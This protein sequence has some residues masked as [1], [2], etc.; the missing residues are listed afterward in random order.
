MCVQVPMYYPS[1]FEKQWKIHDN[2]PRNLQQVHRSQDII[3]YFNKEG[4][5]VSWYQDPISGHIYFDVCNECEEC[6]LERIFDLELLDLSSMSK[7]NGY[8]IPSIWIPKSYKK[9]TLP[10]KKDLHPYYQKCLDIS[11]KEAK[12]LNVEW[13][14]KSFCKSEPLISSHP[15]QVQECFMFREEDFPK[16][17]TFNK[18]GSRHTQKIQN[19]ASTVLPSGETVRPNPS[20]D[21][22]NWQTEK[23]LQHLS[24]IGRH[25]F[26]LVLSLHHHHQ[27]QQ[28]ADKE[29]KKVEDER[30]R[31]EKQ[32]VQEQQEPPS[33]LI[34]YQ[35]TFLPQS[36]KPFDIAETLRQYRRNK[37]VQKD[38]ERAQ[39]LA[40]KEQ[41]KAE[42]ERKRKEKQIERK[43]NEA[44]KVYD[45]PLSSMLDELHD[46]SVPY[47]STYTEHQD[48]SEDCS[49]TMN[50]LSESSDTDSYS[51]DNSSE[52]SFDE[53]E[54]I[55]PQIHMADPKVVLPDDNDNEEGE[56]SQDTPQR[57]TF[58][59]SKGVP[60]FT[61]DNVT[62][63]KWEAKFQEFHAW[64]LAQNLTEESH[65]EILSTFIAHLSGILKDWWGQLLEM[66]IR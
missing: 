21:V 56:T 66:H 4:L 46:D 48:S 47:I 44:T 50:T 25:L 3:Q 7:F 37:Q 43:A 12:Q 40:D 57:A 52:Q 58:P 20:E 41:K 9:P 29:Q 60:L 30:K 10:S 14:P 38:A 49:S 18:N 16:L 17:E 53:K 45:N 33:S 54:E 11:K 19:V 31:K 32:I 39:Q 55:I 36:S 34:F 59:K 6:Q 35:K 61:I 24:E 28:L 65:F 2:H 42:D 1:E 27:S 26:I 8:Q 22:L 5:P 51:T 15:P 63:E 23:S 64:M 13:K 62:P